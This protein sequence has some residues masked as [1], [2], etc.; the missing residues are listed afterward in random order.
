MIKRWMLLPL[1]AAGLAGAEPRHAG[2]VMS[3]TNPDTGLVVVTNTWCEPPVEGASAFACLGA[4]EIQG[5]IGLH[6]YAHII[7]ARQTKTWFGYA[8]NIEKTGKGDGLRLSIGPAAATAGPAGFTQVP[9]PKYDAGPF[10]IEPGDIVRIPLLVN[11]STGQTLIDEI[12]IFTHAVDTNE[13]FADPAKAEAPRDFTVQDVEMKWFDGTLFLNKKEVKTVHGGA[14]GTVVW[15]SDEG[16][17]TAVMSFLP[18]SAPGFQ[19]AGVISGRTIKFT[20]GSNEYE[21]R[22]KE[23]ILPGDGTYNLYVHWDP[24]PRHPGGHGSASTGEGAL[25]SISGNLAAQ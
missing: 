24:R 21:W 12:Q 1:F 19:K 23:P 14:R 5:G 17:G 8:F 10:M 9:L 15:Y 20:I 6:P 11:P 25:R 4:N 13:L 3:W 2:M 22:C 16:I 7:S 18:Q